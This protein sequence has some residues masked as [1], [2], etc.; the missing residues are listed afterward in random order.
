MGELIRRAVIEDGKA[1]FEGVISPRTKKEQKPVFANEHEKSDRMIQCMIEKDNDREAERRILYERE[2][3]NAQKY[4][5]KRSPIKWANHKKAETPQTEEEP[6]QA[7]A[8][9]RIKYEWQYVTKFQYN[10]D[11]E[12]IKDNSERKVRIYRYEIPLKDTPPQDVESVKPQEV[13]ADE[14]IFP[15]P[16]PPGFGPPPI[17][18]HPVNDPVQR[19]VR[20]HYTGDP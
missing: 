8:G 3:R 17:R 2:R 14:E 11:N 4:T 12:A 16:P 5:P 19:L 10:K 13:N 1:R 20:K 15:P 7:S 6:D 18:R 9:A